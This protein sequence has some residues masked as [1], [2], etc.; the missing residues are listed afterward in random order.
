MCGPAF[1]G[2]P[3]KMSN[4]VLLLLFDVAPNSHRD[5][6]GVYFAKASVDNNFRWPL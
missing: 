6:T 1:T 2:L 4:I 5:F 3:A